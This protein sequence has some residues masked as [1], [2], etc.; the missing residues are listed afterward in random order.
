VDYRD[1]LAA[2]GLCPEATA[3]LG[4]CVASKLEK[5]LPNAAELARQL[6]ALPTEL[7]VIAP[8]GGDSTRE[9][10]PPTPPSSPAPTALDEHLAALVGKADAANARARQQLEQHDYAGAVATLEGIEPARMRDDELL[11]R[12][13]QLRERVPQLEKDIRARVLSG[14]HEGLLKTV[15][16]LLRLVPGHAEMSRVRDQLRKMETR[17]RPPRR[18]RFRLFAGA[19]L[20][21]FVLLL[22]SCP[23][24]GCSAAKN[25]IDDKKPE[26]DYRPKDGRDKMDRPRDGLDKME[27]PRDG[28]DKKAG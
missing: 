6:E 18:S 4:R 11:N 26:R 23:Y 8:A 24:W 19:G 10:P 9:T 27:R 1:E 2:L 13:R 21:L 25:P 3:L 14:E 17:E 16:E 28:L 20:I 22:F 5:R 12:A 15:E 7:L